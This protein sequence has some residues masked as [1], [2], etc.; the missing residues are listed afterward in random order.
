[1]HLMGCRGGTSYEGEQPSNVDVQLPRRFPFC[2]EA[3]LPL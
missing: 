2:E 1:M 3:L